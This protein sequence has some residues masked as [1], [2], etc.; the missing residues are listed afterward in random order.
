VDGCRLPCQPEG[1]AGLWLQ[2]R[3]LA[4]ADLR[5]DWLSVCPPTGTK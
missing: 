5:L 1:I 3:K 4:F 2:A